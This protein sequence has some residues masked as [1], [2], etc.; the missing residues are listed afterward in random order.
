MVKKIEQNIASSSYAENLIEKFNLEILD[1]DNLNMINDV[2]LDNL[3]D[4]I[5]TLLMRNIKD[6]NIYLNLRNR[7][8]LYS[9]NILYQYKKI[10]IHHLN[11]QVIT[12][13]ILN[14]NDNINTSD[15]IKPCIYPDYEEVTDIR[16]INA[17]IY[18]EKAIVFGDFYRI[19]YYIN[20]YDNICRFFYKNKLRIRN[21][22]FFK[23]FNI[24]NR[25]LLIEHKYPEFQYN[26]S[27]K[28][29]KYIMEN[30]PHVYLTEKFA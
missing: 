25:E 14:N 30:N 28:L 16:F 13:E 19:L 23:K 11:K 21:Q 8:S 4:K 12:E 29:Y 2:L 26:T 20:Q 3:I 22:E 7:I 17:I 9:Q 24:T 18:P 27:S 10:L 6:I 15:N 5:D 1:I